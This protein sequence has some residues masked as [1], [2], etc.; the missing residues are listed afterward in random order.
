MLHQSR[1]R[2][3]IFERLVL[4]KKEKDVVFIRLRQSYRADRVVLQGV[5]S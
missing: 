1:S 2:E 4:G 3:S 5:R